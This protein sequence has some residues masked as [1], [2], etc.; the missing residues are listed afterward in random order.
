L[1]EAVYIFEFKLT[2][3]AT[4]EEVLKQIDER[5][6]AAQYAADNRKIVKVGAEFSA[7]SR[8]LHRWVTG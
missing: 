3:N 7:E 2:G 4:A 8:T 1:K 5:K 6:Y